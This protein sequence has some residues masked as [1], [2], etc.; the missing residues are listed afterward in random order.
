[1]MILIFVMKNMDKR[2]KTNK[3]SVYNIGYQK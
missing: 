2:W 1:M 3:S